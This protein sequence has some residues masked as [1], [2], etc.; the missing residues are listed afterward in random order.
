MPLGRKRA[1]GDKPDSAPIRRMSSVACEAIR[2]SSGMPFG[3]LDR[4]L[5][6]ALQRLFGPLPVRIGTAVGAERA[7]IQHGE[8][9]NS[10]QLGRYLKPAVQLLGRRRTFVGA[11][12]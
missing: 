10:K 2:T 3:S 1:F 7:D 12:R 11:M 8:Q 4:Q 6:R 5:A 9:A